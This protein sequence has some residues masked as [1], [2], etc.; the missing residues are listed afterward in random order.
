MKIEQVVGEF[1]RLDLGMVNAYLIDEQELT[2]IDTGTPGKA[3]LI[4]EGIAELGRKPEELRHILVTHLHVDHTGSL[5]E[6]KRRTGATVHMHP[7]TAEKVAKGVGSREM[8]R[9]PTFLSLLATTVLRGLMPSGMEGCEADELLKD[10]ELLT[11]AGG[12]EVVHLPGHAA[13]QIGVLTPRHGGV[14][15][16]ADAATNMG[17][18]LS[19]PIVVENLAVTEDTLRRIGALRF[20]AALFGH[21]KPILSGAAEAFRRRWPS[22]QE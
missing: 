10:R 15:I 8:N 12:A 3:D 22:N 16:V 19:Y 14:L 17:G 2:L 11:F 6:L 9:A 1:Y 18:R 4:L 5:A 13:G 20:E 7:V 21:G